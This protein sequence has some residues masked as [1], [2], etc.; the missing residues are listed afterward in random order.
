M[1]YSIKAS[2]LAD[3]IDGVLY[4]PDIIL[5]GKFTFLNKASLNDIV[6][7]HKIN[8]KGIEIAKNKGVSCLIT[9]NPHD[10]AIE[11]AEKLDFTLIV[12]SHIEYATAL[13]LNESV[14]EFAGDALKIA[15]TGTNGKSTTTHLLYTI[16]S[17]LGYNTYTNTDA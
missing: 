4:G 14:K 2:E 15:I 6:I 12:T 10:N 16:F 17:D 11:V 3:K 5:S 8:D 9:Q 1:N 13:A 7:R